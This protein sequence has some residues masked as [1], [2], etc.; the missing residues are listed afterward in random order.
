MFFRALL[1]SLWL[2]IF[3][4]PRG[5]IRGSRIPPHDLPCLPPPDARIDLTGRTTLTRPPSPDCDEI[6]ENTPHGI[7]DVLPLEIRQRIWKEVLEGHTFHL[8]L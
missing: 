2:R 5:C 7:L 3:G 6:G 4:I 1:Q 8:Y